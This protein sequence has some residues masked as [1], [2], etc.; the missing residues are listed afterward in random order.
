MNRRIILGII[1][2]FTLSV[3]FCGVL[4]SQEGVDHAVVDARIVADSND[5][6]VEYTEISQLDD[7]TTSWNLDSGQVVKYFRTCREIDVDQAREIIDKNYHPFSLKTMILNNGFKRFIVITPSGV[8][9]SYNFTI[10]KYEFYMTDDSSFILPSR[11]YKR[12]W[13]VK[14][15]S[16]QKFFDEY[17]S[18]PKEK[19]ELYQWSLKWDLTVTQMNEYFDLCKWV[20]NYL[21]TV[22]DRVKCEFQGYAL[23]QNKLYYYSLECSGGTFFSDLNRKPNDEDYGFGCYDKKGEKYIY[24][25]HVMPEE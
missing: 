12:N 2:G 22:F 16:K 10:E 23:F 24:E 15:L 11:E 1:V 18:E 6:I 8:A 14:I 7:F 19:D 4:F 9:I 3:V 21:L 25:A 20:N 17:V 5:I 13:R